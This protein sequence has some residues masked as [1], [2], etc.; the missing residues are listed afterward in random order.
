MTFF[1]GES[2]EGSQRPPWFYYFR[3]FLQLKIFNMLTF[4]LWGQCVPNPNISPSKTSPRGFTCQQMT[5]YCLITRS[6]NLSILNCLEQSTNSVFKA[7]GQSVSRVLEVGLET[8]SDGARAGS[9]S[10]TAFS[11]PNFVH[12]RQ[13][14]MCSHEISEWPTHQVQCCSYMSCDFFPEIYIQLSSF[15]CRASGKGQ[16][17]LLV[18]YV[19]RGRN[20]GIFFEQQQPDVKRNQKNSGFISIC[21]QVTKPQKQ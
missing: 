2:Q 7:R 15:T 17:K 19:R 9:S 4:H 20:I 21:R 13:C 12:L 6:T 8:S 10:L 5:K 3:T 1:R 16:F 14:I 18:I 11:G